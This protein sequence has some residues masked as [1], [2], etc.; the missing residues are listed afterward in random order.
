[1][2]VAARDHA[3][4]GRIGAEFRRRIPATLYTSDQSVARAFGGQGTKQACGLNTEDGK[5][6]NYS[7]ILCRRERTYDEKALGHRG[8]VTEPPWIAKCVKCA[9][10]FGWRH[11][12]IS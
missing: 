5:Q 10:V 8:P 7:L 3:D 1:M 4:P 9:G 11:K 12:G 6:G 2:H